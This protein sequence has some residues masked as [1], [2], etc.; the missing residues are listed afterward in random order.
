LNNAHPAVRGCSQE[1]I[2]ADAFKWLAANRERRFGIVVLDPP[3]LAKREAERAGA[4]LAYR[5]LALLAIPLLT[6]GGILAA[7]SCSAHV[8][9]GEFFEAV[10]NAAGKS[11]SRFEEIARTKQPPDHPAD[12]KEARYLKAIYLRFSS[13]A[14]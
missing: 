6:A 2:Q 3:S 10:T 4:I 8:S 9:E 13:I 7:C 14:A 5:R 11:N 12:L 1:S